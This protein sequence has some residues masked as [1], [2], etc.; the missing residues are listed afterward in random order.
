[1]SSQTPKA[2]LSK[3]EWEPLVM[4]LSNLL[5]LIDDGTIDDFLLK[6]V[7]GELNP[8]PYVAAKPIEQDV[9]LMFPGDRYL[10][11]D[12]TNLQKSQLDGL[13]WVAPRGPKSN[14]SKFIEGKLPV[15]TSAMYLVATLRLVFEVPISAEFVVSNSVHTNLAMTSSGLV[16]VDVGRNAYKI[17]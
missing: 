12:L 9:L 7:F 8:P 4:A 16:L 11:P 17:S 10:N 13:G 2:R 15:Q 3:N 5:A 1:M 14:Y 6:F